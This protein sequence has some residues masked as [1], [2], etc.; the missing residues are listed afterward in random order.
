MRDKLLGC[1]SSYSHLHHIFQ[2]PYLIDHEELHAVENNS[3]DVAEYEDHHDEDED[4]S[5]VDLSLHCPTPRSLV[6]SD[7]EKQGYKFSNCK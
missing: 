7:Q 4:S 3:G 5:E 2:K 1:L 6:R